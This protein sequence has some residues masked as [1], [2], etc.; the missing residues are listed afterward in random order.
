MNPLLAADPLLEGDIDLTVVLIVIGKTIAIFA[1]LLIGVMLYIW[2]MRKVI[3]DMQN[4]IGPSSAGPFG[5]L[6]SLADGIKLFFKEQSTPTSA[7]RPVYLLAPY[8]SIIP[9]FLAFAIVPIGGTVSIA[10]HVTEL[11]LADPE[12][13]IL[14]L[15]MMSGIGLY[16][17]MLAGW[18]SGSKYPLLGSVRAS[19]QLLSY[20][21][22][23]GLAVVG[24]LVH[25]GTLSTRA[26][27]NQQPWTGADAIVSEWYWL[28]AIGALLI[29][30]IAALAETNHPPFDLVEAEQELVGGFHTEYTGIRFALF[31]LAEFMNLITMCAIAVTLFLGGP[32]GPSLGFVASDNWINTWVMPIFWFMFKLLVLLYGTVWVRASLPRLRYDQLMNIS[33]KVLIEAAFLWAM[34]TGLIVVARNLGWNLWIV[35]PAAAVGALLIYGV[36]M[37]C[38]PK[39]HEVSEEIK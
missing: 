33:W 12:I 22:A 11:Q 10:G 6:Q 28:P 2:F 24:V 29:F 5:I 15:L 13:G 26:I 25:T 9:A 34:V 30:V 18:S 16:G 3:A 35:T 37:A 31:F 7:D 21:A 38:V 1:L 19:A 36:L 27:V 20:E 39:P 17:V 8:L 14:F 23:L 32:S 4:R